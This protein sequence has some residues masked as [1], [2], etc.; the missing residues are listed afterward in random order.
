LG[1][2]FLAIDGL[3]GAVVPAPAIFPSAPAPVTVD[4]D[5]GGVEVEAADVVGA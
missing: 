1:W 3:V 2:V 4:D 5:D